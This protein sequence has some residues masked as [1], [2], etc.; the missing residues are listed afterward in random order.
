MPRGHPALESHPAG[1]PPATE[2]PLPR[3]IGASA[4]E[5]RFTQRARQAVSA[6][7]ARERLVGRHLIRRC[8]A[9]SSVLTPTLSQRGGYAH[10]IRLRSPRWLGSVVLAT[11][12]AVTGT[13][14]TL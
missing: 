8:S 11:A 1:R 5:P 6:Q 12:P 14:V 3:H 13:A 7:K 9:L 10:G 4:R 2:Q